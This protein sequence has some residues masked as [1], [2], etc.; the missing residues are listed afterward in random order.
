MPRQ[1]QREGSAKRTDRRGV[2]GV[3][4]LPAGRPAPPARRQTIQVPSGK[5][6]RIKYATGQPPVLAVRIQEIFGWKQTPRIAGGKVPLLLHLLG[7]H[8]RPVQITDDLQSFWSNAYFQVRK[9]LRMR[10]PKHSW[11]DDPLSAAPQ[12]S[13]RHR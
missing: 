7:P 6:I 10:Y 13:K 12:I 5:H 1:A 9:D 2:A 8:G 3:A 11:P 4:A